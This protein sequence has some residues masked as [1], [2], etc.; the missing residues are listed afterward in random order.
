MLKQIRIT[1]F[2]IVTDSTLLPLQPFTAL[3]GRN[4]SGKSSLLEALDWL[5]RALFA[6]AQAA[7][8]PFHRVTDLINA[9]SDTPERAFGITL[10]YDPDDASIGDQVVYHIEVGE[11]NGEPQIKF[12][13]LSARVRDED[14]VI[15]RTRE[16]GRE[17][18]SPLREDFDKVAKYT[19]S[20]EYSTRREQEATDIFQKENW[21]PV[22]DPD[23]LV[24][25]QI[26]L[27][28]SPAAFRL[29][30]FL[31]QAVFLRLNPRTIA[32]FAPARSERSGRLL[33]D[34]GINL[35]SL[36][37]DLDQDDIAILTRKLR[38][39][40][41][42]AGQLDS[43]QPSSPADRRFFTLTEEKADDTATI[44]KVNV[45]AWVLSEGTRRMTAILALLLHRN[46]PRLIC[47]EEIENGFD[48]WTLSYLLNELSRAIG[49]GQ[50]VIVTTHSPYL[51]D[52]L[53]RDSIILCNRLSHGVEFYA[54]ERLP[55]ADALHSMLGLGS[56]YTSQSLYP[57]QTGE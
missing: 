39:L 16:G 11:Q 54:A 51:L 2:K 1:N 23:R 13:E 21:T 24:L 46:S 38:N 22:T 43:H 7:T 27:E 47:F 33:D 19:E 31:I 30:E 50:Q 15:I 8:E 37:S 45:P 12:E 35:S 32:N 25:A 55:E 14:T 56:L 57:N 10:V 28:T 40:I 29:R 53:S 52:M 42:S 44:S 36:L 17:Y 41:E 5:S 4:G 6:G 18:R 9:W 48:P 26:G 34:E 49:K 20:K 3:I